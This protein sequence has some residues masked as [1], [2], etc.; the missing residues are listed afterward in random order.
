MFNKSEKD[1]NYFCCL[2][3]SKDKSVKICTVLLIVSHSIFYFI[4]E[5]Y[6]MYIRYKFSKIYNI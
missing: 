4:I 6:I 1:S 2:C 3:I 5:I